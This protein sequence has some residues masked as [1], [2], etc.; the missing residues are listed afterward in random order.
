MRA[1]IKTTNIPGV[2]SISFCAI[3]AYQQAPGVVPNLTAQQA[4]DAVISGICVNNLFM[5]RV[6]ARTDENKVT[7]K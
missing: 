3:A 7:S 1:F 6:H 5:E 4:G 2:V